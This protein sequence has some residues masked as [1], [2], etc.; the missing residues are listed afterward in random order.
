MTSHTPGAAVGSGRDGQPIPRPPLTKRLRPGDWLAIDCVTAV[1]LAV[2]SLVG[3]TRPAYGLPISVAYAFALV[4]TLPVAVRRLWPLPVLGVVLA[5][6]LAGLGLEI[7]KPSVPPQASQLTSWLERHHLGTGLSGYWE[8]NIVTLTS[9]GRAPV[10][11]VETDGGRVIQ[12]G[13][14]VNAAWY[15]PARSSADFV[16][17]FPGIDGFPGFTSRKEVLATFGEPAQ[18]YDVG[19]YT[20]L[21]WHKNLLT[22]L[23]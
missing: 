20:I 10:R 23:R 14:N 17:L 12:R 7:S 2:V 5:G 1:L 22:D 4:S 8:A 13:S 16:V 18:T 9:G 6:Y 15:D 11:L 21:Y 3:S 19:R